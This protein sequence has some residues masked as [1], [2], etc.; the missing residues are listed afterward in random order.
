MKNSEKQAGNARRL[1]YLLRCVV[2][3]I[4][5]KERTAWEAIISLTSPP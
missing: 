3:V 2:S 5:F 1:G 4:P